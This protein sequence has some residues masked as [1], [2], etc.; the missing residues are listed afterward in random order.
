[1]FENIDFGKG[2][3]K[4]YINFNI[5]ENISLEEQTDLLMEDLIQI[6]YDNNYIIDIGWYPEFDKNGHFLVCVIK[7]FQWDRPI[8]KKCC[9][10]LYLLEK[11]I[12]HAG[13]Y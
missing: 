7:D 12:N 11:Y 9:E 2:V 6:I 1:M 5:N 13:G 4:K 10:D 8:F 3:S